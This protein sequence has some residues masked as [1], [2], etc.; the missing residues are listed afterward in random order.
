MPV[1]I[2]IKTLEREAQELIKVCLSEGIDSNLE[3]IDEFLELCKSS[4]RSARRR[5]DYDLFNVARK[6]LYSWSVKKSYVTGK[7]EYKLPKDIK[8]E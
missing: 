4:I 5:K 6:L 1:K 3:K 7:L 2:N 8:A